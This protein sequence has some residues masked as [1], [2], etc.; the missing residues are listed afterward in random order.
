MNEIIADRIAQLVESLLPHGGGTM[1]EQRLRM[2]LEKVAHVAYTEGVAD[3]LRSLRTADDAAEAWDVT[4][5][6]ACTHIRRLHER[7]GVGAKVAG[8]WLLTQ[9]EIEQNAPDPKYRRKPQP[10]E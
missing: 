6:R 1:T 2:A 8:V 3:G 10:E 4:L 9:A 5:Q 7:W